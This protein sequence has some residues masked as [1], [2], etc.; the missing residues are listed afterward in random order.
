MKT[1]AISSVRAWTVAVVVFVVAAALS[2]GLIWTLEGARLR[3]VRAL[4]TTLATERAQAIQGNM[5]R[6][7][8][9]A[10]A[11]A[12]MVR[13]G[14]GQVPEF[15]ETATQML[16]FY[17]GVASLQMAVGGIVS[18]IVPL[19]GNEK[20][21]G[22]NL[23]AD[24][25]RT[26]EAF[27]ARDTGQLTLAGPFPLL[28]GGLGAAARLPVFLPG[29]ANAPQFWGFVV[30]LLRFPQALEAA[31]LNL[32]QERGF[33]YELWRTHP[34][35]Q[36]KQ[37]IGSSAQQPLVEPVTR[38]LAVPNATWHLSLSPVRGW[39]DTPGLLLKSA[40]GL[41]FSLLLGG[42]AKLL[43]DLQN[44]EKLLESRVA[45][46][47]KDLQR[48]SEVT[49]HHLQ[50]PARR[51]ASYAERLNQ[52][53]AGQTLPPDTRLSLEFI[54][55]QARR[56]KKLLCD[57]ERYLA[58]DQPRAAMAVT[59]PLPVLQKLLV[60]LRPR[61]TAAGA[62]VKLGDLPA[63]WIDAPR[64][65]DAFEVALDNA[66]QFGLPADA[67]TPA[68]ISIEGQ[69]T[70]RWV[71]FCVAD[72]GPGIDAQYHERLFRVF[73]R[74]SSANEGTGIGL[75]IIR[76]IAESCGGRAWLETAPGGGCRVCFELPTLE[77][78]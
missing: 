59:D 72:N 24:P 19:A 17:P 45:L 22:H 26:K 66:L 76:H 70:G 34:D 43:V 71:R 27:L 47:T 11:L 33:Q 68:S 54:G 51:L 52:Q 7:F 35:T 62:Q 36:N 67:G 41:A 77:T 9:A 8:S 57:M 3:E 63:V 2:A 69:Q 60:Q 31:Q 20:A 49:A 18:A 50:E 32:L 46:R 61:L 16:P 5:E 21:I 58:C 78:S 4:A 44:Q 10:Y 12:A 1:R 40:L 65:K 14:K 48:F 39:G 13:Q 53:L 37:V 64:L 6:A 38:Q 23:L 30:V 29:D 55:Q 56:M 75:A 73:E 74:M 28:Q 25:N 15:A 42:L